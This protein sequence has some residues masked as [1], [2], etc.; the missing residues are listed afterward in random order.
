MKIAYMIEA[1]GP[2]Y[3][4][5]S[6]C[7]G[8]Q[9]Q[10]TADPNLGIQFVDQEQATLVMMAVRQLVPDLFPVAF[11]RAPSAVSHGWVEAADQAPRKDGET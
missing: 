10:W 2:A 6:K 7:G 4:S 1:P 3:L 5:V 8:H 9:F 11:I